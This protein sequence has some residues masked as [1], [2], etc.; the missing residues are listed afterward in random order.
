[1]EGDPVDLNDIQMVRIRGAE[2]EGALPQ[3]LDWV[4]T[5]YCTERI[6]ISSDGYALLEVIQNGTAKTI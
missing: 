2:L 6:T 5:N 1:M 4:L 3:A